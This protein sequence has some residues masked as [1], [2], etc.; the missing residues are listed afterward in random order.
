MVKAKVLNSGD[1]QAI[2]LPDGFHVDVDEV[3]L[4]KT[5][6]GFLVILRDPWEVFHEGCEELSDEFL[7]F[8]ENLKRLPPKK[9]DWTE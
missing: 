7:D 6:E 9:R 2:Q 3:M 8:M 5:P 4:E 1:S